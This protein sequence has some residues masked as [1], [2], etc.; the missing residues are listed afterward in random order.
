ME[1]PSSALIVSEDGASSL[2]LSAWLRR[3][4]ISLI[5]VSDEAG[6]AFE[7]L[8]GPEKHGII[9]VDLNLR[10]NAG[11]SFLQLLAQHENLQIRSLPAIPL[12]GALNEAQVGMLTELGIPGL[13]LKPLT[14]RGLDEKL[15]PIL[16]DFQEPSSERTRLREC[17]RLL[18]EG[19]TAE[20]VA[21]LEALSA[22]SPKSARIRLALAEAHFF[23][24]NDAQALALIDSLEKA[25]PRLAGPK[26]LLAKIHLRA[27]RF[28]DAL[29]VLQQ[30]QTLS[31]LNLERMLLLG[32]VALA[33][34]KPAAA[35]EKFRAALALASGCVAARQGLAKCLVELGT[36]DE[37]F[38]NGLDRKDLDEIVTHFNL[39]GVTFAREQRFLDA[40]KMYECAAKFVGTSQKEAAIRFNMAL[41]YLRDRRIDDAREACERA[42]V[43]DPTHV[44]AQN[45]LEKLVTGKAIEVAAPPE[46]P[47]NGNKLVVH[48]SQ[49]RLTTLLSGA[50]RGAHLASQ[51]EIEQRKAAVVD[52]SANRRIR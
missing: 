34:G 8:G 28:V 41:A 38:R 43:L 23:A 10:N 26:N 19:K 24:G 36:M 49:E 39:K 32:D 51:K 13:L 16:A 12:S 35:E 9:F 15:K 6:G 40:V 22:A 18:W 30:A 47:S 17:Q 31:P 20:A 48:F 25:L 50:L 45:L 44:K 14:E 27:H 52:Y 1:L 3:A 29:R 42:L 33:L 7:Q 2:A 11:T 37:D 5:S 4:G 21:S 46:L